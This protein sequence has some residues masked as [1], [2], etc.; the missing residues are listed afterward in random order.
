MDTKTVD[1]ERTLRLISQLAY[2]CEQEIEEIPHLVSDLIVLKQENV[3]TMTPKISLESDLDPSF[4]YELNIELQK[5]EAELKQWFNDKIHDQL[6]Y[7]SEGDKEN[8]IRFSDGTAGLNNEQISQFCQQIKELERYH[9]ALLQKTHRTNIINELLN[10][11]IKVFETIKNKKK[12]DTISS[13]FSQIQQELQSK[14]YS[15]GPFTFPDDT[16]SQKIP[17]GLGQIPLGE[18]PLGKP[19]GLGSGNENKFTQADYNFVELSA[20][21]KAKMNDDDKNF[22]LALISY[23]GAKDTESDDSEADR[24]KFED[25]KAKVKNN[26]EYINILNKLDLL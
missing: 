25:Y 6:L 26:S 2:L 20:A 16:T 23:A 7:F 3:D 14:G 12:G 5:A 10:R 4:Q 18:V 24:K 21:K 15:L 22:L 9:A 11:F 1:I 8:V 19:L 13:K 17:L